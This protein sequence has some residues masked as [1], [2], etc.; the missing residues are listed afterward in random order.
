MALPDLPDFKTL[1][2]AHYVFHFRPGTAAERDIRRIACTQE[3]CFWRI[4]A[5]LGVTPD[6]PLHY[7]LCESPEEVGRLYGDGIPCH[8]CAIEPD[9]IYATYNDRDQ[10]TGPH[11]DTHLIAYC[12]APQENG[13][14]SEGLAQHMEGRWQ[15]LPN[16]KWVRRFRADGRYVP[17]EQLAQDDVFW[18]LPSGV[19]YPIAGAFVSFL[20]DRIGMEDFLRLYYAQDKVDVSGLDEA[21][22]RWLEAQ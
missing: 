13:L 14:L 9:V 12:I 19:A 21:F 6:Y 22:F 16:A 20:V 17:I 4:T 5:A 10:C 15:G 8:A 3:D 2:T 11:E 18:A 1:E 7:I